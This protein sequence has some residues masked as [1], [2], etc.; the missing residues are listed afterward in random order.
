MDKK[1]LPSPLPDDLKGF[2]EFLEGQPHDRNF[3]PRGVGGSAKKNES[4]FEHFTFLTTDADRLS[5]LRSLLSEKLPFAHKYDQGKQI[6]KE[7]KEELAMIKKKLF[8]QYDAP[9]SPYQKS[10]KEIFDSF[11]NPTP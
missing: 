5:K 4:S 7:Q 2:E 8:D 9:G 11:F 10:L 1:K 3:L 6:V